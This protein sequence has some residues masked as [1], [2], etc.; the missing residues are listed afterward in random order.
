MLGGTWGPRVRN[1]SKQLC[2]GGPAMYIVTN[3]GVVSRTG[4][5]EV[6]KMEEQ[7]PKRGAVAVLGVTTN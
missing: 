4:A 3:F 6:V 2:S 5:S 1:Q 7:L